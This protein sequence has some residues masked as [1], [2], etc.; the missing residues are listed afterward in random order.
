[1][2]KSPTCT[3]RDMD[4]AN[5]MARIANVSLEEVGKAIFSATCGDDK[6]AEAIC[7]PTTRSSTSPATTW[8]WPDH[9]HG[10]RPAAEAARTNF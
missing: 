3:Q 5:R 8:R 2:F 1:M 6:S 10:L 9:L 7:G 4:V